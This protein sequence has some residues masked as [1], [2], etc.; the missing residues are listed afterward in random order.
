MPRKCTR[1]VCSDCLPCVSVVGFL[2]ALS[3]IEPSHPDQ[4]VQ[5]KGG[6]DVQRLQTQGGRRVREDDGERLFGVHQELR[7]VVP[8]L[9]VVLH[10]QDRTGQDKTGEHAAL[11][12]R[13]DM[14][15]RLECSRR[16]VQGARLI[17]SFN[18]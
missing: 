14:K 10:G 2:L 16:D 6:G 7:G 18:K 8:V 4:E 1:P 13:P 17:S 9:E 12:F 3:A 15:L 5:A 11:M